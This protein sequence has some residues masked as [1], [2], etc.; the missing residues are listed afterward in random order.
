MAKRNNKKA[1]KLVTLD[2]ALRDLPETS[3]EDVT[4]GL[5]E[6]D[7]LPTGDAPVPEQQDKVEEG[8]QQICT[9]DSFAD[10]LIEGV[11]EAF[12]PLF[13]TIDQDI[14]TARKEVEAARKT[15][16]ELESKLAKSEERVSL[17]EKKFSATVENVDSGVKTALRGVNTT[18][19][20]I[21]Y[22]LF[23][24]G[25]AMG[26]HLINAVISFFTR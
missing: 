24:S 14:S 16:A 2:E 6:T 12:K 22:A 18:R 4:P 21:S 15:I 8:A 3:L 19:E 20:W 13:D 5:P 10:T 23:L 25:A 9:P 11:S 17:L 7:G 26:L 1:A